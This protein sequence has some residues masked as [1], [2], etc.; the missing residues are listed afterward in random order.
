[1]GAD[2]ALVEGAYRAAMAN[3]PG[4]YSK[5]YWAEAEANVAAVKS[6]I[7]SGTDYMTTIMAN[8]EAVKLEEAAAAKR[9][10][11]QFEK[12][13]VITDAMERKFS[14]ADRGGE[15]GSLNEDIYQISLQRATDLKERFKMVNTT[16]AN[17]TP[18]NRRERNKLYGELQGTITELAGLGTDILTMSKLN[19]ADKLS[20]EA[21]GYKN[22]YVIGEIANQDSDWSNVKTER[23]EKEGLV[24]EVDTA[25]YEDPLTG[26]PAGWGKVRISARDLKKHI[27]P[28]ATGEESWWVA[29]NG[30]LTD[31]VKK[32][33]KQSEITEQGYINLQ[34]AIKNNMLSNPK[35]V[36]DVGNRKLSGM[37]GSAREI[38]LSNPALS[39][40]TYGSFGIK[41]ARQVGN[42]D[43]I[44]T[45]EDFLLA[46]DQR[47][48]ADAIFDSSSAFYSSSTSKEVISDILA[49]TSKKMHDDLV[50]ALPADPNEDP[51]SDT[52]QT[53]KKSGNYFINKQHVPVR[54]VN[55]TIN[56]LDSGKDYEAIGIPFNNDFKAHRRVKGQ[57]Q[58]FDVEA[59]DWIDLPN[60]NQ[61]AINLSIDHLLTS[62][63]GVN[64]PGTSGS[65]GKSAEEI[66]MEKIMGGFKGSKKEKTEM[67]KYLEN[68]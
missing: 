24:F 5:F 31:Q 64:L 13:N 27:I 65:E 25:T 11:E 17:D 6:I 59:N 51:P 47:K 33:G 37:P 10:D 68:L 39:T 30:S 48:I 16:G 61:V 49:L 20:K 23:T 32:Q 45:K 40:A 58:L 66:K 67:E 57:Y 53:F 29:K 26:K 22:A 1:M 42:K 56:A 34:D 28:K 62:S 36:A 50:S 35:A 8:R 21:M 15:G 14:S 3:V 2:R 52:S 63:G 38:F 44:I 4:D 19:N 41:L 54:S 7:K 9:T 43:D 55:P 60:A 18:E 12:F 46:D